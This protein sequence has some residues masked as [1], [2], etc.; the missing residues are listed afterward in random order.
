M[1]RELAQL[2]EDAVP[3][4][5]GPY[6]LL[7]ANREGGMGAVYLGRAAR[8][9][10]APRGDQAHQTRA[11]HRGGLK[12]FRAER[13]A[14][15]LMDHSHIARVLDAGATSDGLPYFA[16]EYVKGIP[17]HEF[18]DE[19]K[20]DLRD[21]LELFRQVCAGVQHAHSKGV[22]HR[23]LKPT[24]VLVTDEEGAGPVAKIIDFGLAR[25]TDH[26]LVDERCS[27]GSARSSA[28]RTTCRPSRSASR[29]STWTP[30]RTSIRSASC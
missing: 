24:N 12:R 10:P 13:Q 22:I 25:A 6:R 18:C 26:R 17:I 16:M 2:D 3:R 1:H 8:A 4:Q 27:R 20:I 30:D 7:T 29:V 15:A 11:R 19:R 5:I 9:G 23:D 28:R 14:L 21:R